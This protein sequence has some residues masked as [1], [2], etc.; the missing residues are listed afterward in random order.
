M[1]FICLVSRRGEIKSH[2]TFFVNSPHFRETWSY[3]FIV[4]VLGS[5]YA[6][7]LRVH[8]R[9]TLCWCSMPVIIGVSVGL[10]V[11]ILGLVVGYFVC[12]CCP[13]RHNR[14]RKQSASAS[15]SAS[16]AASA[17][18][19]TAVKRSKQPYKHLHY[20]GWPKKVNH[21]QIIKKSYYIVLK[22]VSEIRLIRQIKIWIKHYNII[23]WH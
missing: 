14:R 18:T 7:R 1:H 5:S 13:G 23:R 12:P 9:L 17:A 21:Y 2:D 16:A 6:S 4:V 10:L 20:T 3:L 19:S 8:W 15:L 11:F 22:S